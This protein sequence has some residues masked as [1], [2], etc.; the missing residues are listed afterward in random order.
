VV[1]DAN[2]G[3]VLARAQWPDFNPGD[4]S[5]RE[6]L[7]DPQFA[8]RDPKFT[9]IYGPWPDKTGFRGIY[10]GGSAAKLFTSVVAARAG[11]LGHGPAC[12]IKAGPTFQ[13]VH[14]DAQGPYFTRPGWYAP[15]HDISMDN[16]HGTIEFIRGLA[17]SCNVYFGQLGL[18]LGPDA[19][20]R[21][22]DDGLDM[23][24]GGGWYSP[25]KPG[26]RDL[27]LTA[28]GQHAAMMSI[29]Q[30]SRIAG[31]I[32]G[33]GVN[34]RCPPTMELGAPCEQKQLVDDPSLMI[35]VLAGMEQVVLAGTARGIATNP[36][37]PPGL[38]VYGKTGTADSIGIVEEKPWGVPV[39]VYDRPHSWFISLS[40]PNNVPACQPNAPKR[41]VVAVV[42]PR[43]GL[44]SLG[45]APAAAEIINAAYKLGLFGVAPAAPAAGQAS[46][47]PT[48]GP[49]SPSLA[50]PAAPTRHP[51]PAPATPPT[52]AAPE[53]TAAPAAIP[54]PT[55]TPTPSPFATPPPQ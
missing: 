27:A 42:I 25:G 48:P 32:G 5:L 36:G 54:A 16:P 47:S 17:V 8:T 33:G 23:G 13:C 39:G 11:V 35:P 9:G 21:L 3:E 52:A 37:L 4:P 22:V 50:P 28:F 10:Q 24:F 44:G 1:L 18:Q 55:P 6:R 29:S 7:E 20:K 45:A 40:E 49:A 34:R 41:I 53:S 15:V 14:R 38:R 30:A 51:R 19:F 12:P 2:T 43:G 46:P 31:T 26:S